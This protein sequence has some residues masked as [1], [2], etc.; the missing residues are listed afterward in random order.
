M[1]HYYQIPL[2]FKDILKRREHVYCSFE[3]SIRQHL[4]L[5]ITTTWG[6][7][8]LDGEYGSF[9]WD[10]DFDILSTNARR[11]EMIT[12]SIQYAVQQYEKRI[13][14]VRVD[15]EIVQAEV[16]NDHEGV[17]LKRRVGI[18]INGTML[19]NNQPIKFQSNFFIGPFATE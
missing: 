13:H 14:K 17:N 2:N 11:K 18:T 9:F 4:H 3:D 16:K 7:C 6:E 19:K 1:A 5:L 10:N 12:H 8:K 15:V